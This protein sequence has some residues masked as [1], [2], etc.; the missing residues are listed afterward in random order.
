M[1]LAIYCA[2]GLGKELIEVARQVNHWSKIIFVDDVTEA[3][4]YRGC[5]VYRFEEISGFADAVE[6][7]IAS[8]EP[9][10]R[11]K[12]YEKIKANGYKMATII[13][14]GASTLPGTEIGEGCVLWDCGISADV[15]IKENVIV[16]SQVL[17]GHDVQIGAHS[18]IGAKSFLGGH[19]I[20]EECVYMAPGSMAKDR[21]RIG[22][23]SIIGMGAV[24]LRSVKP[25]SVLVGNPA[26]RIG[27]NTEN[28]V[29]G[30]FQ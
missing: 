15:R 19:T 6:F 17:M 12:L 29:F 10:G 28:K 18:V 4:E 30:M 22:Q 11:K 25:Y 8:G 3:K 2:G 5:K 23:S 14:R 26:R 16:N 24:V 1:I 13:S 7:I 9:A 27:E 20:V 21:L